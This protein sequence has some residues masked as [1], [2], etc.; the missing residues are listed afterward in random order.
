MPHP[1]CN[2]TWMTKH[3]CSGHPQSRADA[4][5]LHEAKPSTHLQAF[6][7]VHA[8][9]DAVR[10]TPLAAA[11]TLLLQYCFPIEGRSGAKMTYEASE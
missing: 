2:L 7:H 9:P 5:H 4:V 8:V 10:L 11:A 3:T 1:C 6:T